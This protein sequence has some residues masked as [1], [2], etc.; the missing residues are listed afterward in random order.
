ML[1]VCHL[2]TNLIQLFRS[3]YNSDINKQIRRA[4][5]L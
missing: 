1:D 3:R 5:K 4:D 2:G